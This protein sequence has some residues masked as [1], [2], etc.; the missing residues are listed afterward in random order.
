M[1]AGACRRG[2][3]WLRP[4]RRSARRSR[5]GRPSSAPQ[6][7][8]G[9][10]RDV[11]AVRDPH[12]A[13]RPAGSWSCAHHEQ[14][15]VSLRMLVG[16]GTAQDPPPKLGVANMVAT[17]L[18]QGT[19]TRTAQQIADAVD[20]VGGDCR[21][22]GGHR[23][24][25]RAASRSCTDSLSPAST[26]CRTSSGRPAFAAGGTRAPARPAACRR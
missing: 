9:A 6:A 24:H 11:P 10:R 15:S 22:R 16:A 12:A 13:Q 1:P 19:T 5:T 2:A 20:T 25:V 14:P 17:L 3:R 21:R 8:G 26:C 7:A 4:C 18:D 23:R